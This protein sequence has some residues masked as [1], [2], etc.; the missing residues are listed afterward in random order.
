MV[1]LARVL[2]DLLASS[3]QR[4]VRHVVERRSHLPHGRGGRGIPIMLGCVLLMTTAF[5]GTSEEMRRF[6]HNKD[7][8]PDQWEHYRDGVLLHVEVDRNRDGRVDEWTFYE[9]GKLVRTE[10]DT[11]GDGKVNQQG[12]SG[13]HQGMGNLRRICADDERTSGDRGARWMATFPRYIV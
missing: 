12:Q 5:A 9:H 10:F 7:G 1:P 2:F 3:P 4:I 6:D 11:D 13:R 8:K